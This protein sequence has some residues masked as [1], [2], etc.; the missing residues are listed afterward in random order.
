MS[1]PRGTMK[2]LLN[3]I[4][5]GDAEGIRKVIFVASPIEQKMVDS[6]VA[7]ADATH[8]FQD[9]AIK[10]FGKEGAKALVGN[11]EAESAMAISR[12]DEMQESVQGESAT[13]SPQPGQGPGD[14]MKFK[15]VDG[16]WRVPASEF[17]AGQDVTAIEQGMDDMNFGA[18]LMNQYANDITSGK[19]E[20]AEKAGEEIRKQMSVALMKRMAEHQAGAASQP[21]TAPSTRPQ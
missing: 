10:Q 1:S 21:T 6:L 11:S 19:Y 9:A 15:K 17:V 16:S 13:I 5:H 7:R 12:I 20:T 8:R 2:V 14:A 3:A 4:T 18:G